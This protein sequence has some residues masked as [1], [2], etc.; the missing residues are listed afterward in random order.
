MGELRLYAVGIDEVRGMF[1]ASPL[2]AEHL[3]EDHRRAERDAGKDV[4][5][6]H[7]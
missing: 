7:R 1:G 5:P 2:V 6:R 4:F 3:R